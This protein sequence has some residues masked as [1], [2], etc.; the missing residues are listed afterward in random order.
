MI[1]EQTSCGGDLVKHTAVASHVSTI[2]EQFSGES[3]PVSYPLM[4]TTA[5][6]L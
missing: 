5:M 6:M 3:L 2:I 1:V 4:Y